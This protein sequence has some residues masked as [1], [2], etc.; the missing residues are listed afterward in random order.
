MKEIQLW[1]YTE[2][3]IWEKQKERGTANKSNGLYTH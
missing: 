3:N 2:R 1:V